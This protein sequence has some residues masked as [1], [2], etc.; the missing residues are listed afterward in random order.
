V[1]PLRFFTEK[2]YFLTMSAFPEAHPMAITC[3]KHLLPMSFKIVGSA[4]ILLTGLAFSHFLNLREE[5]RVVRLTAFYRLMRFFRTQIDCYCAPV[6]DILS[7]VDKKTLTECGCFIEVGDFKAFA[8]SLRPQP[9]GELLE[10]LDSFAAEL[11]ASYR[12]DQLKCCDSHIA[13]IV[14]LRDAA[15]AEASRRK[16]LNTT[17][18]MSAA[19]AAVILLI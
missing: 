3:T 4:V 7:R 15:V 5:D 17:L 18:C 14:S 13:R 8:A 12:E 19:A 11:G 16:K 2:R 1:I 9:T 10:V 6:S